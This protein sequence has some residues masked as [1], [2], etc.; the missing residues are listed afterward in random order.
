MSDVDPA[1]EPA[2]APSD[3]DGSLLAVLR[4]ERVFLVVLSLGFLTAALAYP[5]AQVAM[6]VGFAFAGYSAV[7]NDSIQTIGTF[8]AANRERPW[9]QLWGFIGGIFVATVVWSWVQ[10][11]GDVSY[12]RLAT[13]GFEKAP[14]SFEFLQIAAPL[15]LLVLTRMRMPVSTTFLLLTSFASTGKS[16]VS[17]TTKSVSG[18]AIA[19]VLAIVVWGLFGPWM[20]RKFVGVAHPVWNLFLWCSTGFLWSVW[21]QQDAANIAVFL[22]R[23]LSVGEL[24]VFSGTIF[25]GLGVLFYKGGERVQEV[26]D[27]KSDVV[28]PRAAT[29]I[30]LIYGIILLYFKIHSQIPMSTTWVFVGL[31]GGRELAMAFRKAN[32]DGRTT[33]HAFKLMGRDLAYVTA[34]FLIALIIASAI[35]PA[36]REGFF[37]G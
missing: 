6:W 9:W 4:R 30:N 36:V 29:I 27:E 16:I 14:E 21:L 28:D 1:N 18:Y 33:A 19:F 20:K 10:Y 7:A 35:N 24:V 26:V 12:G 31:L 15:F 11:N 32:S 37:G 23:S 17:V 22:P 13:K 34:G 8:L 5:Y 25:L 2:P 3:G